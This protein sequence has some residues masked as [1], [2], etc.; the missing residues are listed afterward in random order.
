MQSTGF[1]L[2]TM[3]RM[4]H[5]GVYRGYIAQLVPLNYDG[6]EWGLEIPSTPVGRAGE[7]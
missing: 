4:I 3:S 2:L 1:G 7:K 6:R 5:V